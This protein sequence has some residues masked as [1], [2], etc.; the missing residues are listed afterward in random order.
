MAFADAISEKFGLA[1]VPLSISARDVKLFVA[2]FQD[3]DPA[4]AAVVVEFCNLPEP[5]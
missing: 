5:P 2:R 1:G 3:E 4:S